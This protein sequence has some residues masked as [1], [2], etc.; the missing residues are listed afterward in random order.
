M[1]RLYNFKSSAYLATLMITAHGVSVGALWVLDLPLW[2][3]ATISLLVLFSLGFHL[4]KDVWLV[5]PT[6]TIALLLQGDQ[7]VMTL[8]NGEQLPGKIMRD[9]LVTPMLTILNVL[10]QGSR[11]TRS[12]VILPDTLDKESFRKLRVWLKWSNSAI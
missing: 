10:P 3:K 2:A 11:F 7:V 1:Q 4:R 6:A 8:H 5:S 9:S 12:L